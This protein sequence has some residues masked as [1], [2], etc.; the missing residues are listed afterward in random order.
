MISKMQKIIF[1]IGFIIFFTTNVFCQIESELNNNLDE[2]VLETNVNAEDETD[3]DITAFKLKN[4]EIEI[5]YLNINDATKEDLQAFGKFTN[6]QIESFLNYRQSFGKFISKYEL[7]SIPNWDIALIKKIKQFVL[8]KN[9]NEIFNSV[10]IA[11]KEGKQILLLRTRTVLE[12]SIGYN[13]D[14]TIKSKKYGGIPSGF[15]MKY[16]FKFKQDFKLGILMENDAGEK[17]ALNK[18]TN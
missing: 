10:P 4:N 2:A 17:F 14:T 6:I 12:K 7:Q 16:Q 9:K 5:Q 1:T 3:I 8:I 11:L 18:K 15:S 13:Y